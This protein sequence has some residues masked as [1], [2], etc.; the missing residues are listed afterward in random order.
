MTA[1][2]ED[3]YRRPKR[4]INATPLTYFVDKLGQVV[5]RGDVIAYATET[6]DSVYLRVAEVIDIEERETFRW[7]DQRWWIKVKPQG[8]SPRMIHGPRRTV[9][10]TKSETR[11][12]D[13]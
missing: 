2:H 3:N 13:A 7:T 6:N 12:K 10:V 11:L 1:W 9:L 8:E 5:M 4:Q